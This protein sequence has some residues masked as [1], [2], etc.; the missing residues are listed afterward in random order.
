MATRNGRRNL[1]A[2]F[3]EGIVVKIKFIDILGLSLIAI[4]LVMTALM[5]FAERRPAVDVESTTIREIPN[6]P[7]RPSI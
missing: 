4:G 2:V 5:F 7:A 6:A 1:Y 3:R